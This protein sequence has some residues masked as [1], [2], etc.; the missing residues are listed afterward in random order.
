MVKVVQQSLGN[1]NKSKKDQ[2]SSAAVLLP[3]EASTNINEFLL[4]LLWLRLNDYIAYYYF[5]F[6]E[7]VIL[8]YF[9]IKE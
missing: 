6:L 7:S 1:Q 3:F 4:I 8:E 9:N 5:V 2:I